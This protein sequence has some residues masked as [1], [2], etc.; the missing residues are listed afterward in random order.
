MEVAGFPLKEQILSTIVSTGFTK[1][2]F[3][4]LS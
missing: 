4:R 2:P 3:G 1:Q